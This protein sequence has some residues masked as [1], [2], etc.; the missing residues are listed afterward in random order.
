MAIENLDDNLA[1]MKNSSDS[2]KEQRSWS[3]IES[4]DNESSNTNQVYGNE[5]SDA[6][7]DDLYKNQWI[8]FAIITAFL[9]IMAACVYLIGGVALG[10]A[11]PTKTPSITSEV[12]PSS[13]PTSSTDTTTDSTSDN[14]TAITTPTAPVLVPVVLRVLPNSA[15]MR[16]APSMTARV[17]GQIKRGTLASPLVQS[18]EGRWFLVISQENGFTGWVA[19]ELFETVSGDP[20]TLPTV[21]STAP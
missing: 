13:T 7:K 11:E 1:K 20:K 21:P 18:T 2:T 19:S 12:T 9:L 3:S 17:I 6:Y 15:N 8:P 4:S 10:F 14:P 16:S 5:L